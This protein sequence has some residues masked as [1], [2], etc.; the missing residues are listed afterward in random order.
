LCK[1]NSFIFTKKKR[2][3]NNDFFNQIT[4]YNNDFSIYKKSY[5]SNL[6]LV[7]LIQHNIYLYLTL[8]I[9]LLHH[10]F[11]RSLFLSLFKCIH[12]CHQIV[13]KKI[14]IDTIYKVIHYGCFKKQKFNMYYYQLIIFKRKT[15]FFQ[16]LKY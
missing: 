16:H 15:S 1:N 11:I 8:S 4:I 14:M 6:I 9:I 3:Y 2:S 5:I 12:M 13:S 10:S 7:Q